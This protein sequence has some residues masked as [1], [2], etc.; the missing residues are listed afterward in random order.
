MFRSRS[1]NR[2]R[3]EI[4]YARGRGT[5]A[6]SFLIKADRTALIDPPGETF[7]QIYVNE[8]QK[9]FDLT[10]LDYL[11]LGHT[12][13]N[14]IATLKVL[15]Q[16]NPQITIVCSNP[17]A[18][19]LRSAFPD[20]SLSLQVIRG[21]ESL[22]LGRDHHLQLIP[23]PTPRWPDHLVTYDPKTEILFTD[24]LFG[25]HLCGDQVFDEGWSSFFEERKYYFDCL[26]TPQVR[27]VQAALEKI[28]PLTAQFYAPNH[29]PMVRDGL[30]A[31][32]QLYR[33]QLQQ[34]THRSRSVTLLYAS[35]YGN[36]AAL[37][38]GIIT[39]LTQAN[40]SVEK[41]DC[42]LVDPALIKAAIERADGV[43][44]G[45]PTLGGH[46]P[47]QIQTAF[48]ILLAHASPEK[49]MGV[50][51]SYGWSGEAVDQLADKLREAGFSFGFDPIRVK[52]KPTDEILEHCRASGEQF[53]QALDRQKRQRQSAQ[54][55]A[56][57]QGN[58][59][60]QALSRVMGPLCVIT[61]QR[62][63]QQIALSTAQVSQGTFNPPGFTASIPKSHP[64]QAH[65]DLE[66]TFVINVLQ[67]GSALHRQ[68]SKSP[69]TPLAEL[70]LE[71]AENGSP[72]LTQGLAYMECTVQGRMDCQS[73][74]L[75]YAVSTSGKVFHSQGRTAIALGQP[76][77]TR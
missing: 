36:T 18:V 11:I 14:R 68:F 75:I 12:N 46:V 58:R 65:L 74:W 51:G 22:D 29:G 24:K 54:P 45:S 43:L 48:G 38:E 6:N 8:L 42:E 70:E 53:A 44:I 31:L 26:I 61:I 1:W 64:I 60:E 67:E 23:T 16:I 28:T 76:K 55:R 7:T 2:L 5:T 63:D 25:S 21:E 49:P 34:Q 41:V 56:L 13:A 47:T 19:V 66:Q 57:S 52:F 20:H 50:F 62:E 30:E 39:G 3:F 77:S 37:A 35:A 72:I 73:H 17:A 33:T 69:D 15:L 32:L 10:Q 27:Q 9:R 59:T 40:V 4:E 71:T